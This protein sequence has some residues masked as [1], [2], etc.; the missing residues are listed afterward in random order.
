MNNMYDGTLRGAINSDQLRRQHINRVNSARSAEANND[1]ANISSQIGI[2]NNAMANAEA[3]RGAIRMGEALKDKSEMQEKQRLQQFVQGAYSGVPLDQMRPLL[4]P[5]TRSASA[6]KVNP[7][8]GSIHIYNNMGDELSMI[9]GQVAKGLMGAGAM[10]A[11]SGRSSSAS[12]GSAGTGGAIPGFGADAKRQYDIGKGTVEMGNQLM[13]EAEAMEKQARKWIND[14]DKIK[15]AQDLM[16]QAEALRKRGYNMIQTAGGTPASAPTPQGAPIQFTPPPKMDDKER[17]LRGAYAGKGLGELR[18]FL[19]GAGFNGYA[20]N[21][22]IRNDG[23]VEVRDPEDNILAEISPDGTSLRGSSM[24]GAGNNNGRS[25]NGAPGTQTAQ[26]IIDKAKGKLTD[27]QKEAERR[28]KETFAPDKTASTMAKGGVG[29]V[30]A[31]SVLGSNALMA[32]GAIPL[33]AG[34]G[35]LAGKALHD[36]TPIGDVV[37]TAADYYVGEKLMGVNPDE[38]AGNLD[39][40]WATEGVRKRFGNDRDAYEKWYRDLELRGR[41]KLA[42]ERAGNG[43]GAIDLGG[44]DGTPAEV[45]DDLGNPVSQDNLQYQ[46]YMKN[47]QLKQQFPTFAEYM[48]AVRA[49]AS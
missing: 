1:R 35:Y 18:K 4:G 19:P 28:A 9:P 33:A 42:E 11:S 44:G 29:T 24:R 13:Q 40:M 46:Y 20:A 7:N 16:K 45:V 3:G 17:F 37:D 2:N 23:V 14:K 15:E 27:S 22:N 32:T 5:K 31:G 26:S 6:V 48:A 39:Q 49:A 38:R 21:I 8:D 43:G 36:Y 41:R 12:T 47:P 34:G 10:P 30:L 25:G